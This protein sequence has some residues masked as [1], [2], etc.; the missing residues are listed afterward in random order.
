[1]LRVIA[2]AAVSAAL[3]AF[4]ASPLPRI[5]PDAAVYLTAAESLAD[6]GVFSSCER[7]ITEYAPG[8]SAVLSVFVRMG[9]AATDAARL[10]TILATFALVLGAAALARAAGLGP[11]ATTLVA[12]ATAVAPSTLRNG[13]AAWSEQLFCA[14]LVAVF[15]AV[16]HRGRG[17][18]VR[19]S[20]RVAVVLVLAWALLL[21]RYSGLFALPALVLAAWLGSRGLPRR[22]LRVA[23]FAAAVPAVPAL[24]YSRNAAED[25]S[26]F[27]SRS[28]PEDS[29][30]DVLL[31]VPDGLSSI[32][33][34]VDVPVAIRVAVL[35][36][37][38]LV[39]V[40]SLRALET[41]AAVLATLLLVYVA[42][43]A[44]SATQT[45]LD[46]VDT[47]LLSPVFVPGAV[48]VALGA[49]RLVVAHRLQRFLRASAIALLACMIAIAPGIVWYLHGADRAFVLDFPVDCAEWPDRYEPETGAAG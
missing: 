15:A 5:T 30:L 31:Q 20:G 13:A 21:T 46:P 35:V 14:L 19:A 11:T 12:L 45:V 44:W 8:Y 10:V 27:G 43:M 2:I 40:V 41:A 17:L 38:L 24:W 9:M 33:L 26:F 28:R 4:S 42:G 39:A 32:L 25:G 1:M 34:P 18:E 36:L 6:D 37:V 3:V 7:P 29:V 49:T 23:A 22:G 16:L 48:L 47:R